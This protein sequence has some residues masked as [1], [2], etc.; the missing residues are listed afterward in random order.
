MSLFDGIPLDYEE[1][2]AA[3]A[4]AAKPVERQWLL[5]VRRVSNGQ[6]ILVCNI[7]PPPA[8]AIA[9]AAKLGLA[10]FVLDEIQAIRRAA[11]DGGSHAVDIIIAS[12]LIG[13]GAPIEYHSLVKS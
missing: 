1:P 9:E 5:T 7:T 3:A 12:R 4:P 13:Y 10:L 6:E 8:A 11:A 2:P